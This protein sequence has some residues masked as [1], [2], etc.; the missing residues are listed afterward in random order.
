[1]AAPVQVTKASELD[2][3]T[4]QTEGMIRQGAIT[5]KSD[6]LSASGR[7]PCKTLITEF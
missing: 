4:G 5:D 1:M 6:N 2:T 3:N 7:F